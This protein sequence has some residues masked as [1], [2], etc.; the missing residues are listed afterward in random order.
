MTI[1]LKNYARNIGTKILMGLLVLT[2][3]V[4]GVGDMVRTSNAN[5]VVATVGDTEIPYIDYQRDLYYET[6]KIKRILGKNFSPDIIKNFGVNRKVIETLINNRLLVLET[7]AIGL[8][9]DDKK[10]AENIQKNKSF[11]DKDGNFSKERF[12]YALKSTARSEKSYIEDLR[13][14]ITIELLIKSMVSSLPVPEK[15]VDT[16]YSTSNETRDI[17]LYTIPVS[18]I[19][20]INDP[21][22]EQLRTFYESNIAKFTAPEYRKISYIKITLDDA[23]NLVI[24]NNAISNTEIEKLY[25][26]RIDDFKKPERRQ[27]EQLLFGNKEAAYKAYDN[28]NS[29]KDF[30]NVAKSS[31]ILNPDSISIGTVEESNILEE[32]AKK[33]FSLQKN[34]FSDPIESSFGWHI[35]RVTDII[36]ASVQTLSEATPKLKEELIKEKSSDTLVEISNQVE[37]LLAGG[38]NLHEA[39]TELKLEVKS[40]DG[41]DKNGFTKS[42]KK[43]NT[44]PTYGNFL[45]VAFNTDEKSESQLI[46]G[47]NGDNYILR[48]DEVTPA[49]IQPIEKIKN[50]ATEMWKDKEREIRLH[51]LAKEVE[52]NFKDN[53]KRNQEIEKYN[54]GYKKISIATNGND[55]DL[56]PQ[57][58][59]NDL[60]IKESG[61]SSNIF[62]RGDNHNYVIAVIDEI[63]P[64]KLDKNDDGLKKTLEKIKQEYKASMQNEV[65][66]Q[67]L[68]HL[69]KKYPVSINEA[70][71]NI[72]SSY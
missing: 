68:L 50:K 14:K 41:I 57:Y 67:Y 59:V 51:K 18:L 61:E 5:I 6:E 44:L 13:N 16:I 37:D 4:W 42:G 21:N 45:E 19:K 11:H 55:P 63:I 22:E 32:A 49:Y 38:S 40:L 9:V 56:L 47:K 34:S 65:V 48:V 54:L 20:S 25:S 30:I 15:A 2:F 23:K 10:I 46:M 26:E 70:A 69:R 52:S 53:N 7:Q 35:F 39:A 17:R 36:P 8:R 1:K 72:K 60:F 64:A 27:V 29:G 43:E 58:V 31:N 62:Q 71:L 33:V 28:L 24:K 3:A 66:E 12:I